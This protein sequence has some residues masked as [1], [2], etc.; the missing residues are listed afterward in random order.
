MAPTPA[1][2]ILLLVFGALD[3]VVPRGAG[4]YLAALILMLVCAVFPLLVI[5]SFLAV[6]NPKN[7]E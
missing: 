6:E 1:V 5:V 7:G 2:I 4:T 3:V